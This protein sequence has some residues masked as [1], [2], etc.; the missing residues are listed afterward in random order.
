M[1][2]ETIHK[3]PQTAWKLGAFRIKELRDQLARAEKL[4]NAIEHFESKHK[5]NIEN[6]QMYSGLGFTELRLQSIHDADIAR[7]VVVKLKLRLRHLLMEMD[8]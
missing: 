4:I 5:V 2:T 3:A 1:N 7:R 6:A 8:A